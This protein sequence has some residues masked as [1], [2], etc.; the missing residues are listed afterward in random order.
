MPRD[1]QFEQQ[2]NDAK[3]LLKD[4]NGI[5]MQLGRDPIKLTDPESIKQ[6]KSLPSDIRAAKRELAEMDG[7]ASNLF[8][9]LK[10][11]TSEFKNQTSE[12]ARI[13]KGFRGLTSIVEDLRFEEAGISDL[14]TKQ[15]NN[16]YKRA[17]IERERI[18]TASEELITG[19]KLLKN[20][21]EEVEAKK[22]VSGSDE[23]IKKNQAEINDYINDQLKG[24]NDKLGVDEKLSEEAK[25]MLQSYFDQENTVDAIVQKTKER[26][27]LEKAI[28]K[29]VSGFSAINDIVG[30][31]PGLRLFSKPFE[32]AEKAA[33][34]TAK[35]NALTGASASTGAAGRKAMFASIKKSLV[36]IAALTTAVVKV[37][38]FVV[39]LFMSADKNM[40]N[41]AKNTGVTRTQA[42]IIRKE[43]IAIAASSDN[44]LV[45][46]ES[47]L[48]AQYEF[49]QALGATTVGSREIAEQSVFLTENLGISGEK[50]AELQLL[51]SATGNDVDGLTDRTIAFAN[52]QAAQNGYLISGQEIMR[53]M[54]NTSAEIQSYYGFQ[55]DA[56][57]KAVFQTRKLG[58][59]LNAAESISKSLLNFESSIAGELELELLTSKQM[60]FERARALVATGKLGQAAE[61]VMT[62]MMS[63]TDEQMK[64][65][66]ILEAAAAASGLSV[67]QISRARLVQRNLNKEQK[68]YI[69]LLREEKG[70]EA[71]QLATRLGLQG[72]S[73]EEII[74]T[75]TAQD[76]FNAALAKAKD[77]FTGLVDSGALQSI[78]DVLIDLTTYL[79][80][81]LGSES[82]IAGNKIN[83]AI[84]RVDLNVKQD[85]S[86][87]ESAI[88]KEFL[89]SQDKALEVQNR[90]TTL[91]EQ[92]R[93]GYQFF[94][95]FTPAIIDFFRRK[96]ANQA[97]MSAS[98][99][100]QEKAQLVEQFGL[101]KQINK[102]DDFI[103]RPGQRPIKYNQ[104]D[105]IMGGTSLDMPAKKDYEID[106]D[107]FKPVLN[108][109]VN[110]DSK[111]SE[112]TNMLLE[113]LISAVKTGGD[114]YIDGNKAG[115]AM[116]LGQ[117]KLS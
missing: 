78:A 30:A 7:S 112:K 94:G 24:I 31:I 39:D 83:A 32:D 10:A 44:I 97:A 64:S 27:D 6:L 65:P 40:I 98:E 80:G 77:Q 92:E 49:I 34:E 69:A 63:L 8:L 59:N 36:G 113:K 42:E 110:T 62:Q 26:L 28:D 48:K 115:R 61:E 106:I 41:I 15:L 25:A 47:L 35:S 108:T 50:A 100:L 85:E 68:N 52:A 103:L 109:T 51:L 71:A 93:K 46:S 88:Y 107:S 14:N 17:G 84:D 58:L 12:Q 33:R 86:L 116:V 82:K 102:V 73:R 101:D 21:S 114:V 29:K 18:Q 3:K 70:E 23:E 111:V 74:R 1:P 38:Q 56:L 96:S 104:D 9:K 43:F 11:V 105:L 37:V 2:L 55:A 87:K 89:A 90:A 19:N 81:F 22:L 60:N 99:D 72:A 76:K 95:G 4:L 5:R 13:R 20:L 57:A 67:E 117:H 53:D 79:A 75:L 54:A 16:L 66:I 91:D 45:N